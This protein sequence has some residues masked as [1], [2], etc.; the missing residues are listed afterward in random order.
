MFYLSLA[1]A[2]IIALLIF[3][4]LK[5]KYEREPL[6]LCLKIALFGAIATV[7]IL[8][9]EILMSKFEYFLGN[10]QIM[11]AF[12]NSFMVAGLV[13]ETFKFLVIYLF[14]WKNK[15]F[16]EPF[17]G[18]V[19]AT[20]ASLGF[21]LVENILYVFENG[22]GTGILRAFTAVPAHTMFGITMGYFF[23]VA[24]FSDSNKTSLLAASLVV[25]IFIHGFYD[26]IL[27]SQNTL[28]LLLFVPFLIG[29]IFASFRLMKSHS[30]ESPFKDNKL[31]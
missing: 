18:I 2:P 28:L 4:Y 29:M 13:E 12:W 8:L 27:M 11:K 23:G 1:T 14:I 31:L 9:F 24:K 5:D 19:Y 16:D 3:V 6:G 10:S 30:N 17:D 15:N 21:A 20:F 7:P 26:F 22:A 25:P